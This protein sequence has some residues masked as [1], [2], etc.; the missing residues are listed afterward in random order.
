MYTEMKTIQVL[1]KRKKI[2]V[3]HE[4]QEKIMNN[5]KVRK[6]ARG[7]MLVLHE[8]RLEKL[9]WS[10]GVKARKSWKSLRGFTL[11]PA[12]VWM[13]KEKSRGKESVAC[14]IPT[15]WFVGFV[16]G[17]RRWPV[18]GRAFAS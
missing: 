9:G 5:E 6:V 14:L 12:G 1:I 15:R 17:A 4:C 2:Q 8:K 13:F 10:Q 3:G 16:C 11:D 7:K 18:R